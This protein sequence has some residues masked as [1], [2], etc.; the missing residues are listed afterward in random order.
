ML[1]AKPEWIWAS[2]VTRAASQP[3]L[4]TVTRSVRLS[5]SV[6]RPRIEAT[7]TPSWMSSTPSMTGCAAH[8]RTLTSTV[9][10]VRPSLTVSPMPCPSTSRSTN[11]P[12]DTNVRPARTASAQAPK[13]SG[14]SAC[15]RA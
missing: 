5:R 10:P 8:A 11:A 3:L 9:P 1:V 14:A 15:V 12:E 4:P 2:L 7:T 13:D 6:E